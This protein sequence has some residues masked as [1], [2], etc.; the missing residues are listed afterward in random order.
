MT[1]NNVPP[2]D[3]VTLDSV[4]PDW[5]YLETRPVTVRELLSTTEGPFC[6]QY[7]LQIA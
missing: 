2:S 5:G 6:Y 7:D 4:L 3:E 1:A